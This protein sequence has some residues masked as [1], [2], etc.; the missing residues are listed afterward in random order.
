MGG[1]GGVVKDAWL[2]PGIMCMSKAVGVVGRPKLRNKGP[3]DWCHLSA[4]KPAASSG[5]DP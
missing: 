2:H 4:V 5:M 3:V 1:N